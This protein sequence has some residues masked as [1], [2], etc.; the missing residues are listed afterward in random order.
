MCIVLFNC[1]FFVAKAEKINEELLF[2]DPLYQRQ[3][4]YE[5]YFALFEIYIA[6]QETMK[7]FLQS[8]KNS[9]ELLEKYIEEE[10]EQNEV[11]ACYETVLYYD[12]EIIE[13]HKILKSIH[14][15]LWETRNK[16]D[17]LNE[18]IGD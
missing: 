12:K 15:I 9:T 2:I 10:A 17:E 6:K 7:K 1:L 5:K 14:L 18:I 13:I 8:M 16:I 3:K 11:K 4:E